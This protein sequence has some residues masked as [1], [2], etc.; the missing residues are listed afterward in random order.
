M[1]IAFYVIAVV[2]IITAVVLSVTAK[3]NPD[4]K[5]VCGFF[6]GVS[7]LIAGI[8]AIAAVIFE[9]GKKWEGIRER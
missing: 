3:K 4:R 7:V 6:G 5:K 8:L 9:G 2:L 1:K